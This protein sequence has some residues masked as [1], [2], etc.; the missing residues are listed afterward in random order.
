M[1]SRHKTAES[2]LSDPAMTFDR[3]ID[4]SCRPFPT[5]LTYVFESYTPTS[6]PIAFFFLLVC[7]SVTYLARFKK[8]K[9]KIIII[10][11]SPTFT[12]NYETRRPQPLHRARFHDETLPMNELCGQLQS[13]LSSAAS[14][15]DRWRMDVK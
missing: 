3:S 13:K 9:K 10:N 15:T 7:I 14:S 5:I 11:K 4:H 12:M 2:H 6:H 1:R 8:K